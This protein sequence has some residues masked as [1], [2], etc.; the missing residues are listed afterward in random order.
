MILNMLKCLFVRV[1]KQ[2]IH[3]NDHYYNFTK[4]NIYYSDFYNELY[5]IKI[6][7]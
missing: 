6:F 7:L 2:F 3:D 5:K 1:Q 4:L